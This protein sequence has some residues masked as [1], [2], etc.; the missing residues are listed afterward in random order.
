V[1]VHRYRVSFV[2][3]VLILHDARISVETRCKTNSVT[4]TLH[5]TIIQVGEA[6]RSVRSVEVNLRRKRD[7][8]DNRFFGLNGSIYSAKNR[9]M[10]T[11]DLG[12]FVY[13]FGTD[14]S[15]KF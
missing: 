1:A 11:R 6:D 4:N 7:V 13:S 15:S 14:K 5:T 12:E 8:A 3:L 2:G 9:L 10:Q